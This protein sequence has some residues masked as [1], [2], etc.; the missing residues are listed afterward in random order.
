MPAPPVNDKPTKEQGQKQTRQGFSASIQTGAPGSRAPF[1]QASA[2]YSPDT[3][4]S[5][6][7]KYQAIAPHVDGSRDNLMMTDTYAN[8]GD[9]AYNDVPAAPVAGPSSL[10][11]GMSGGAAQTLPSHPP[12]YDVPM[13]HI[14]TYAGGTMIGSQDVDVNHLQNQ[15][16][17]P[18][19]FS[20]EFVPWLEYLPQDVL[21]YFGDQQQGYTTQLTNPDQDNQPGEHQTS[22]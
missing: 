4:A 6:T 15:G 14:G 3:T 7:P 17:F 22:Q 12:T 1:G 19:S 9:V 16:A 18:F 11:Y 13:P 5:S 2:S 20:N 21:S 10:S 8:S